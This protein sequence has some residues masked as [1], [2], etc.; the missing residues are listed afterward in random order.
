VGT[1][2]ALVFTNPFGRR[3]WD[4]DNIVLDELLAWQGSKSEPVSIAAVEQALD[5]ATPLATP[6]ILQ[7]PQD[8]K[9]PLSRAFGDGPAWIR[10]RDQR[11]MSPLL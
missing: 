2:L 7:D 5:L 10:T 3:S 4:E 9:A 6:S 11:I 8:A 1:T